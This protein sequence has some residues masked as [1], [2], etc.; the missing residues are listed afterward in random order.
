MTDILIVF[1]DDYNPEKSARFLGR[2]R[3][4][5]PHNDRYR[6]SDFRLQEHKTSAEIVRNPVPKIAVIDLDM[7]GTTTPNFLEDSFILARTIRKTSPDTHIIGLTHNIAIAS[8]IEETR[9]CG[10]IVNGYVNKLAENVVFFQKLASA[11]QRY[12]EI[13][14]TP[15]RPKV[16]PASAR[17]LKRQPS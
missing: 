3:N 6:F 9:F 10:H 15:K 1:G 16:V 13:S 17:R 4:Y 7:F 14:R 5:L 12:A 11:V 2:L 8:S